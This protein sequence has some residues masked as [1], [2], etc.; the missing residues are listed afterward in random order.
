[1]SGSLD[2]YGKIVFDGENPYYR[3]GDAAR[4][5]IP[6]F[7]EFKADVLV[8]EAPIFKNSHKTAIALSLVQGAIVGAA[9]VSNIR[10]VAAVEPLKWQT[11]IGTGLLSKN[12]KAEI[13]L[14]FP[15]HTASWYTAKNRETRKQMTVDSVNKRF[16][17][18]LT[19]NDITDAIGIG[20][21]ASE[22][23]PFAK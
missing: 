15:G 8:I 6:F 10:R 14:A 4:K 19:D 17:L 12:E 22:V 7:K 5:C 20:W 13:R 2:K 9:Q 1:M 23:D 11:H 18:K 16:N 3:A 21:F